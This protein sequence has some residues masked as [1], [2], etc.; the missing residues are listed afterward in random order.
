MATPVLIQVSEAD[1][2]KGLHSSMSLEQSGACEGQFEEVYHPMR[3]IGKGAFGV[4]WLASRRHDEQEVR[5][6]I[7]SISAFQV[8]CSCS[9]PHSPP[10]FPFFNLTICF[11]FFSKVVVKF[12]RKSRVVEECW[13]EDPELGQVTQEVA[14]LARLCHPNI[15]KV[16]FQLNIINRISFEDHPEF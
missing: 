1:H 3:P 6:E 11:L 16:V 7:L 15:V 13:V 4:V 10:F 9:C 12:I 5:Q 8:L 14:I 2:G